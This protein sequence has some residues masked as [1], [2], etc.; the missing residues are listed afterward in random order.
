MQLADL[1]TFEAVVRHGSMNRAAAELNT[2][3][4]N[5]TA[6]IRALEHALG[7]PLFQRH[8]R[9]VSVTAAGERIL[10]LVGRIAK[11]MADVKTAAG[12]DGAPSGALRL[13]TLETTLSLRLA[14]VLIDFAG[15]QPQVQLAMHAGTTCSLTEDVLAGR[16]DAA[17]VVGPVDH[18][19][20]LAESVLHEELVLVTSPHIASPEALA[21]LPDVRTVVFRSGCS[22][23]Q[24][25]DTLLDTLGAQRSTPL[26]FGSLDAILGCVAAGLG[27]TL[28]PRVVAEAMAQDGKIR[29]HPVAPALAHAETLCIRRRDAY[30]S[31]ALQAFVALVRATHPGGFQLAGSQ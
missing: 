29:L 5:V 9:G 27:V 20:L 19:E 26:E 14:P 7:T 18:P 21:Q 28:L 24:R 12:D 17:F 2:V 10:P 13:G 1:R 31:S 25:L 16:V 23:R 11:L 4:S 8:A 15:A 6:R 30:L 22:Y 3:Q